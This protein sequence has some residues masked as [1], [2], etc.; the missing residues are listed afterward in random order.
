[1]ISKKGAN[2][3]QFRGPDDRRL[4]NDNFIC[5][6]FNRLSIID[7]SAQ[8]QPFISQNKNTILVCNGEIY[9]YIEL[10]KE[11]SEKKI[12]YFE[13]KMT[14]RYYYMDTKSGDAIY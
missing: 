7:L 14:S 3:T 12:I 9:N 1:M 2:L 4:Y 6:K 5:V 8:C 11:L 10:K 13:Q